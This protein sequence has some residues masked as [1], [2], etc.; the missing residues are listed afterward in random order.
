MAPGLDIPPI[1][2]LGSGG[3]HG[4]GKAFFRRERCIMLGYTVAKRFLIA[5]AILGLAA[6]VALGA[7]I[8]LL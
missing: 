1:G 2:V 6:G 8:T 3:S 7:M 5:A 4:I